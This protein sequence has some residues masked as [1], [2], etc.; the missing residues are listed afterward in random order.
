MISLYEIEY[1]AI[2]LDP[3]KF[4][5]N[6]A[7]SYADKLETLD[8]LLAYYVGNDDYEKCRVVYDVIQVLKRRNTNW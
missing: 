3:Q 7:I 5:T 2:S 8:S 1:T 4:L 6:D